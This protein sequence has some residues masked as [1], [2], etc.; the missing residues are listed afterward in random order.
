[1][2]FALSWEAPFFL[3]TIDRFTLVT[4][5][6]KLNLELLGNA[7]FT[8]HLGEAEISLV[9]NMYPFKFTPFNIM[10]QADA[11]HPERYCTGM[12]YDVK[13]FLAEVMIETRINECYWGVLGLSTDQDA[14]DCVWRKYAPEL[15]IYSYLLD[16]IGNISGTYFKYT[17]VNWYSATWENWPFSE[18]YLA[19]HTDSSKDDLVEESEET[20]Q[21]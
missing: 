1:M 10:L 13:A 16:N 20:I 15:P 4:A 9:F 21:I 17:C 18:E 3:D 19:I 2:Q 12:D 6:P 11:L 14:K 5:N 8:A 7:K